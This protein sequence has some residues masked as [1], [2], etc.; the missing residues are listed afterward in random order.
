MKIY[1]SLH[2]IERTDK[3][4]NN[5]LRT[6][7]KPLEV[8]DDV[9][10]P[11]SPYIPEATKIYELLSNIGDSTITF[12]KR[13]KIMTYLDRAAY[14]ERIKDGSNFRKYKSRTIDPSEGGGIRIWRIA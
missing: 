11:M 10:I 4:T 7:N 6:F 9:P 13:D 3:Q 14:K 1:V 5:Y 8:R 2:Y 12:L